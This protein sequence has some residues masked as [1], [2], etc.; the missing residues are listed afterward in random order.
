MERSTMLLMR[1]STISMGHVQWQTVSLPE[2]TSPWQLINQRTGTKI[3]FRHQIYHQ[4]PAVRKVYIPVP[5]TPATN[6]NP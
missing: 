5:T 4:K 1:K 6:T 3:T 2:G